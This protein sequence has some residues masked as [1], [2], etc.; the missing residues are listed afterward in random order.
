MQE[1]CN[2][3][4]TFKKISSFYHPALCVMKGS[5]YSQTFFRNE[6]ITNVCSIKGMASITFIF[7]WFKF[8]WLERSC[9]SWRATL[10]RL[11]VE[12]E[13]PIGLVNN[14]FDESV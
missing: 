12:V 5:H 11:V 2:Y 14:A 1:I 6:L 10:C 8:G 7:T 4:Q 3:G 9:N 13:Q